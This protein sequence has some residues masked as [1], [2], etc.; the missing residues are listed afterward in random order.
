MSRYKNAKKL[1]GVIYVHRI[2]DFR[3]GGISTRNFRMFRQ[4]CGDTTLKNVVIV[5]N[6][7]G[8]VEKQIGDARESELAG[9]DKFFKP[10]LDKGAV[11]LRHENTRDSALNILRQ[12]IQNHPVTLQIQREM[13]DEKK[14]ISQTVAADELNREIMLQTT[15]FRNEMRALKEEMEGVCEVIVLT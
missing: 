4:L 5:T 7:W 3:M 10:A 1:A 2:S 9:K 8:E 13:V 15:R 11:M 14:D 6:M 12:I